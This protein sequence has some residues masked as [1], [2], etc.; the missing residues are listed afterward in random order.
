M[1]YLLTLTL[2]LPAPQQQQ[3]QQ[4]ALSAFDEH[5]KWIS[6]HITSAVLISRDAETYNAIRRL[7]TPTGQWPGVWPTGVVGYCNKE[8]NMSS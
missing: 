4:H 1:L 6:P 8:V 5:M 2:E 7:E 3:Q